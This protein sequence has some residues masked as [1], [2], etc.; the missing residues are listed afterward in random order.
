MIFKNKSKIM[1]LFSTCNKGEIVYP[2]KSLLLNFD[3][4]CNYFNFQFS[5]C[6]E[7]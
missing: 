1:E 6:E 5:L 2:V 7:S 3:C 4:R